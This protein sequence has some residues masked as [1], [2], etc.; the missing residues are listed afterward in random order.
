LVI[1][2]QHASNPQQL[3]DLGVDPHGNNPPTMQSSWACDKHATS[4]TK[5]ST[6]Q[7]LQSAF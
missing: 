2:L 5:T 6:N 7:K 4:M 3:L 1:F